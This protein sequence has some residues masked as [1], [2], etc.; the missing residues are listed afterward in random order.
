[1]VISIS[2]SMMADIVD[3]YDFMMRNRE[4]GLFFSI[5]SF[6]YKCTAGLGYFIAGLILNYIEFPKKVNLEDVPAEQL[7]ALGI[8]GGPVLFTIYLLA[9]GFILMYPISKE[10]YLEI[11]V[12]LD[13]RDGNIR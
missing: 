11:R 1:M 12:A 9:I 7:D 6:A 4:E 8:I 3:V 2:N 10:R 13:A 5:M